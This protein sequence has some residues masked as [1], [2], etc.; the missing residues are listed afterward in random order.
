MASTAPEPECGLGSSKRIGWVDIAKALSVLLIVLGHVVTWVES[1]TGESEALHGFVTMLTPVRIPMFFFVSGLFS[2]SLLTG[3]RERLLKRVAHLL[4]VYVLWSVI[5]LGFG[6]IFFTR[7]PEIERWS[8]DAALNELMLPNLFTWFLWALTLFTLIGALGVRHAPRITLIGALA[9]LIAIDLIPTYLPGTHTVG[10][11]GIYGNF[12]FFILPLYL[13][14]AQQAIAALP[15]IGTA[16]ATG[17]GYCLLLFVAPQF[18]GQWFHPALRVG[19]T[20]L[21]VTSLL[22]IARLIESQPHIGNIMA[23]VGRKTLPIYVTH[24]LVGMALIIAL[25]ATGLFGGPLWNTFLVI[26]VTLACGALGVLV[27]RVMPQSARDVLFVPSRR[28]LSI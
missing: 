9:M 7:F 28:R 21:G 27:E 11:V 13:P 22:C 5:I 26:A 23:A 17:M 10:G 1:L 6:R 14:A 15:S 4:K 8:Y 24:I 2:F 16:A 20:A 12:L 19:A 3:P 18:E 25:D